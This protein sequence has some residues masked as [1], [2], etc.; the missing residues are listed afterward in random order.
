MKKLLSYLAPAAMLLL[1]SCSTEPSDWTADKKVSLDMVPPGTRIS[2]NYDQKP[3][4]IETQEKRG[5]LNGSKH[6]LSKDVVPTAGAVM[7]A[8][9]Q[10]GTALKPGEG[11]AKM[12][13]PAMPDS[14]S[15]K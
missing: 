2:E 7:S 13:N 11:A 10:E 14:V 9:V 12:T 8:D 3:T 15:V 4:S 6:I 1:A 5:A